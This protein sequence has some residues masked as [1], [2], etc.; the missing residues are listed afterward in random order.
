MGGFDVKNKEKAPLDA[1]KI[2]KGFGSGNTVWRED[3]PGT[4]KVLNMLQIKFDC[5]ER[6]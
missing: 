1:N 6:N 3:F 2:G 4:N 5:G